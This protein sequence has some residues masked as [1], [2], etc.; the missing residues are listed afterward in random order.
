MADIIFAEG[1]ERVTPYSIPDEVPREG[2]H[3][4]VGHGHRLWAERVGNPDADLKVVYLHGGP[5]AGCKPKHAGTIDLDHGQI[6]MVDQ[7][8]CGK[9]TPLRSLA[10][11]NTAFIAQAIIR[12]MDEF[13]FDQP[14]MIGRSWGC[15]L[16]LDLLETYPDRFS[17]AALGGVWTGRKSENDYMYG[18]GTQARFPLVWSRFSNCVPMQY[19]GNP[20]LYYGRK[21]VVEGMTAE[22]RRSAFEMALYEECLDRRME[23]A[24]PEIEEGIRL[25]DY[26]TLAHYESQC[27]NLWMFEDADRVWNGI[28][29]LPDIPY[30]IFNGENDALTPKENARDL[31]ERMR[32]TGKIAELWIVPNAGHSTIWPGIMGAQIRAVEEVA[33]KARSR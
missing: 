29:G 26:R 31:Y 30:V 3:I 1:M 16:G 2:R 4:D 22:S 33:A 7:P 6:L 32:D 9:S 13:G 24:T 15:Y 20:V 27:V 25:T 8:G 14:I 21:I 19:R 11:M 12:A 10:G 18:G 28:V 23:K 17:G 5:G